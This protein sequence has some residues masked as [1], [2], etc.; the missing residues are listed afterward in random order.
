MR[1]GEVLAARNAVFC[2]T[3]RVP[4]GCGTRFRLG[5]DHGR[6]GPALELTVQ[7]SFSQLGLSKFEGVSQESFVF[8]S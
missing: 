5:A 2:R 4:D 7:A 8:T 3:E 6:I 1:Y